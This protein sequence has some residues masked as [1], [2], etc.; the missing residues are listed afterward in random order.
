MNPQLHLIIDT[1]CTLEM[2]EQTINAGVTAVQLRDKSASSREIIEA[3]KRFQAILIPRKIPFIIND[4]VDLALCL[5]A[6]GVHIGQSDLPYP[7][8]RMLLGTDKIIGLTVESIEQ[9]KLADLYQVN[10]IG[11]GPVFKTETK[12]DAPLPIDIK[13]LAAIRQVTRH[14]IIAVGGINV[15]NIKRVL[16]TQIEGVAVSAAICKAPDPGQAT[17]QLKRWLEKGQNDRV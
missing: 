8:A 5:N 12:G 7:A 10:Y 13:G 4:R 15:E 14:A 11:V 17:N 9:A 3:G 2:L 16:Q 6:D 1:S